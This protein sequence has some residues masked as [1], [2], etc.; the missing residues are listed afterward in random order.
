MIDPD[1]G[2][3]QA[4]LRAEEK[5]L[6]LVQEIGQALSSALDLDKLLALIMEKITILMEA[7][8]ST[9]FLFSDDR[10]ELWSKVLQGGELMEIRLPVGAGIAGWVAQSSEIVNIPDAYSDKRF[11]PAVDLRSGFRTRSILC[12]PM[13]MS[14]GQ[15]IGVIQVLNKAGGPFTA[16]DEALLGA[17][18]S[19]AAVSI[20]NS[21]LYHSVVA[22]NVELATASQMLE[23][24]GQELHILFEIEQEMNAALSLDELLDR[25]LRRAMEVIS[26]RAGSILLRERVTGEL[27]FRSTA[28][29]AGE[30]VK[31]LRINMGEGVVGW[32]AAQRQPLIV[33][34]PVHDARHNRQL[35]QSV[36]YYPKNLLCVPLVS[37]DD[38]LGAIE[39]LDKN[40]AKPFDEGDLKLLVLIAGQASKAIQLAR[41]KEDR[42]NQSRLA[43]IGQMLSGMLHDL[44]TPMT[45]VSGYAQ[46][47]A[48]IDD[49]DQ[50]GQYV[51]QI[52]KQFD[53]MSA[54]TREVLAFARG[55]SNVLIRKVFLHKFLQEVEAHLK[56]EFGG[57]GVTLQI[58]AGF[59]GAAYFDEQKMLRVVHN[60]ARN[61]AQA[62]PNGGTFRIATRTDGDLLVLEF[63]DTGSGIP[64]EMEGR[65]FEL[66]ATSGKKDG[67][68]LGLA[69]VKKIVDEHHG[70]IS[71]TSKRGEGSGTTFTITIPIEKPALL[72]ATPAPTVSA[73]GSG[74]MPSEGQG[75]SSDTRGSA[76]SESRRLA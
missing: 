36:N 15:T 32:V 13:R 66:F 57:K 9:L 63:A 68:G 54:M 17:L 29:E 2:A 74:P 58:D 38:V 61:A 4:R 27:Y 49:A 14:Q 56:H 62:M 43:S 76:A 42:V 8:R 39:L 10:K 35:A 22:K 75:R 71:Y 25:I 6:A 31:R 16:E 65:L 47:M 67:T 1:V 46:L 23:Q 50:R 7:D 51:E 41:A 72:G 53:Q 18:A 19:Q 44:K 30:Q 45:I 60:I 55:E 73:E 26:V 40:G 12:M 11:Y 28:G 59:R 64:A 37:E 5:K 70:K 3:L 48:Q 20:E 69:I 21:K 52:L 33:N 34:D 24:R